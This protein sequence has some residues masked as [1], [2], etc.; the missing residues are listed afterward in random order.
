MSDVVPESSLYRRAC[1]LCASG[2]AMFGVGFL[3][4]FGGFVAGFGGA[5][6]AA[7]VAVLL[8]PVV[9]W[10]G[11][12]SALASVVMAAWGWYKTRRAH[13][14]WVLIALGMSFPFLVGIFYWLYFA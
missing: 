14:W 1:F 5:G 4:W 10:F 13:P 7:E 2:Y 3:L 9:A 6:S 12:V 11:A 8:G